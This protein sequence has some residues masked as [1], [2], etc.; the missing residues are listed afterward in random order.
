M[1]KYKGTYVQC[2]QF[3]A[4]V[5]RFK[6]DHSKINLALVDNYEYSYVEGE[7]LKTH[8]K[9]FRRDHSKLNFVLVD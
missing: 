4:L 5:K 1:G 3:K 8:V 2:E 7:Q 6:T 9:R